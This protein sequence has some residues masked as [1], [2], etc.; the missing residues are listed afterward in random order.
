MGDIVKF[1]GSRSPAQ[2]VPSR[3]YVE[4]RLKVLFRGM[5]NEDV[6]RMWDA[7]GDDSFYHGPEGD[8]DCADIHGY[9]NMIGD[10]AY[11]AV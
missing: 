3:R 8:F 6:R 11:C 10:G 9:L 2:Y 4:T 7:V 1:P 5:S